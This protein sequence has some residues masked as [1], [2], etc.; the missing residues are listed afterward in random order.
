MKG[1]LKEAVLLWT[2][3]A[4]G[5]IDERKKSGRPHVLE[6]NWNERALPK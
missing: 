2:H 6:S 4:P 5:Q 1:V 3:Q